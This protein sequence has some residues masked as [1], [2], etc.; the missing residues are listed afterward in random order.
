M[1]VFKFGGASVKDAAGVRN[2][3]RVIEHFKEE[4]L[5]VVVSAMGKTTN[6]LEEVVWARVA[7]AG[8][9]AALDKLLAAHRAVLTEVA[10]QDTT[11]DVALGESFQALRSLLA[12]PIAGNTDQ[13]YDQVVA[14]GEL[15][16]TLVVSAHL[17]A[18]DLANSW[19][20]ART[21]VRTDER[22][23][24]ANVDWTVSSELAQQ[25]VARI[26]A[27]PARVVTQGFIGRSVHGSTTT[28]GREGSDFS[29]AIFAYLLDAE[30][31]TIWKDVPGMFN[32]D[33][34]RFADTRLLERISYKEAIELSYFGASV[35]HPRTLQ[36][37][38][39]KGIPLYVRSFMDLDAQGSTISEANDQDTLVPSFIVK[40]GQV[41]LSITPRDLSF[42]VE[43][44]LSG[45]FSVFALH[46][47]RIN[48]MQNSAVAFTVAIDNDNRVKP[49]VLELRRAYE[50]LWNDGV[51]LITVRHYDEP[52]LDRLTSGREVL[53]EQRSRVT[54]RYVV[55]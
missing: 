38:Q 33:P 44:N 41:L 51:E 29:A 5:V 13:L 6:A 4:D 30:S 48:L 50:V 3:A 20:D 18:V 45:I 40:P 21:V 53:I 25:L 31:V 39:K 42:I 19:Q 34:N 49:L 16:S 24:S 12:E 1:K 35:I 28:L 37:L 55:K 26:P 7:D 46:S 2:V 52:T 36:P 17:N 23:R 9:D 54:A 27:A 14:F 10:P 32:A 8:T 43:E 22:Y 47:V 11:V 15:W